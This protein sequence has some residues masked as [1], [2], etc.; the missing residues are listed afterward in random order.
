M[1]M[2]RKTAV[3]LLAFSAITFGICMGI[4]AI[5]GVQYETSRRAYETYREE[6]CEEELSEGSENR[7]RIHWE[8]FEDTDVVGW[9]SLDDIRYPI[10]QDSSN[11]F[12]LHHLPDGTYNFGG[13]LFLDKDNPSN[14]SASNNIIYG[15]NMSDGSMFGSLEENYVQKRCPNHT[16]SIDLPDG[17]RHHYRFS[18]VM[19]TTDGSDVYQTTFPNTASFLSYQRRMA[20]ASL[21]PNDACVQ[22]DNRFVTLSTCYG[23]S[24]TEKRLAIQAREIGVET[25]QEDLWRKTCKQRETRRGRNS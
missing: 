3:F 21:Y 11:S 25:V 13:S 7:E 15:H 6:A 2:R 22:A 10:C 20:G 5:K 24:G 12:Y 17:T 4:L 18:S 23:P 9:L 19:I 14:F 8:T 16:F 1:H